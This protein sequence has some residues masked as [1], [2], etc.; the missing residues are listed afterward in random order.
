MDTAEE[1]AY[2]QCR[3]KRNGSFANGAPLERYFMEGTI[4][5]LSA[6]VV[7]PRTQ[8]LPLARPLVV[9]SWNGLSLEIPV[10]LVLGRSVKGGRAKSA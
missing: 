1:Y 2:P 7:R 3:Q 6:C 10:D 4:L 8:L 5:P 9:R